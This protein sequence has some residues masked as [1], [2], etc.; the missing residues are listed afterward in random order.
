MTVTHATLRAQ[1]RTSAINVAAFATQA[2]AIS[3]NVQ[4]HSPALLGWRKDQ[5]PTGVVMVA[6]LEHKCHGLSCMSR[7]R[8][9]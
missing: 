7:L 3:N 9:C 1:I 6:R 5:H 4:I 2:R 8:W